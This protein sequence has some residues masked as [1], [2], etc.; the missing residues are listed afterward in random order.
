MKHPKLHNFLSYFKKFP[1][2]ISLSVLI[3]ALVSSIRYAA[4]AEI[5]YHNFYYEGETINVDPNKFEIT[6]INKIGDVVQVASA[7]S[8][9]GGA[10]YDNYYAICCDNFEALIIYESSKMKVAHTISTGMFNTKWHCNQMFFGP[11]FYSARDKF[12]LLYISM[13]NKDERKIVVTRI[14]SQGGEYRIQIVQTIT[15]MFSN[16]SDVVYYPNAYFDYEFRLIYWAG[17]TENSYMK[18]DTNKLRFYSFILPDYREEAVTCE[19]E[20]SFV[21]F[22]L[23]SETATQGGFISK[24]YLYQTFS[25]ASKTDP[26]RTP[27]MRVVDLRDHVIVKDYQNLG[28]LFGVYEEFEHVAISKE[29]RL[30]A[31]GNPLHLYEFEYQGKTSE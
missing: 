12:P 29:G 25:F 1:V 26:L 4:S 30:L 19:T 7:F 18:S 31:L 20:N 2:I 11:D 3:P 13:E 10:C 23:P 17:Y 27:K 5:N 16:E 15:L 8:Y 14:Y 22:E 28:E 21:P 9:Q 6:G 24:G